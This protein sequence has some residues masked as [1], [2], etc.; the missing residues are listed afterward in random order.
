MPSFYIE[1][2]FTRQLRSTGSDTPRSPQE[3]DDFVDSAEAQAGRD[4]GEAF[5][6]YLDGVLWYWRYRGER[7][8]EIPAEGLPFL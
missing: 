6:K 5:R 2:L 3:L 7:L 1:S 8:P 4:V